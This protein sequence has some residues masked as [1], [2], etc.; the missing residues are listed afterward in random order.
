MCL[1]GSGAWSAR[2]QIVLFGLDAVVDVFAVGKASESFFPSTH[3]VAIQGPK[4]KRQA[5]GDS[6]LGLYGVARRIVGC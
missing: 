1:V 5:S 4:T 2:P 6:D 3:L